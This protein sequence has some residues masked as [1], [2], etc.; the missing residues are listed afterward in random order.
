MVPADPDVERRPRHGTRQCRIR[1][2]MVP[3]V[4]ADDD[5]PAGPGADPVTDASAE[6]VGEHG[7]IVVG[8]LRA[9]SARLHGD[10]AQP[11][12]PADVGLQ[13]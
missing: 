6:L 5:G 13:P 10:A 1:G 2:C 12:T 11:D 9:G 4:Q 7:I 3:E 8:G